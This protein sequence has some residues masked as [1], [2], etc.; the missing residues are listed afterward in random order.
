MD[1]AAVKRV[2]LF[3]RTVAERIGA[4]DEGFLGRGRPYGESRIL[5]EVGTQGAEVR[6]LRARLGLDSGYV[7]RVL[8]SLERSGLI[9][10]KTTREDGR[11]SVARLTRAGRS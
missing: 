1:R 7:S 10:V 8:R 11:V 2:R 9:A 3:N 5:W 6:E 4:L